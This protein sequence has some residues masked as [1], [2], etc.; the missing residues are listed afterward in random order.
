MIQLALINNNNIMIVT[1][2]LT[3]AEYLP[4][5]DTISPAAESDQECV[6]CYL[7]MHAIHHHHTAQ[8]A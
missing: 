2:E 7:S 6:Q 8:V 3:K 4:Q 5:A 1:S